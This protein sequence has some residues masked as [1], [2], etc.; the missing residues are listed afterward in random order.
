M[1]LVYEIHERVSYLDDKKQRLILEIINNF[2]PDED[3][4]VGSDDLYYIEQAERELAR[5]E[6]ISHNDI[7]WK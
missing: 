6:T 2:L 7:K 4:E 5:G 1:D 3:D